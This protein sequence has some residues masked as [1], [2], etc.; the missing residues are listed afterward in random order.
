MEVWSL[1]LEGL[2]VM[3]LAAVP[4]LAFLQACRNGVEGEGEEVEWGKGGGVMSG[5]QPGVR[6]L[7]S[8]KA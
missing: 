4:Y 1:N 8:G 3:E 5:V 6:L 7:G 2:V